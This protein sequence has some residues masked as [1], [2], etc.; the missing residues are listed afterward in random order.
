MLGHK[1]MPDPDLWPHA[2]PRVGKDLTIALT[3]KSY[4]RTLEDTFKPWIWPWAPEAWETE[5]KTDRLNLSQAKTSGPSKDTVKNDQL[6][7]GLEH[8]QMVCVEGPASRTHQ[9]AFQ[10]HG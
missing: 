8:L 4:K 6:Q 3:L 5:D 2:A 9:G 7:D 10:R 1:A